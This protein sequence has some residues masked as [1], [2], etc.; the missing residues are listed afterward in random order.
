MKYIFVHIG[1]TGG[2]S[3][4]EIVNANTN[5]FR[6]YRT[7]VS[8][9]SNIVGLNCNNKDF[10]DGQITQIKNACNKHNG[11]TAHMQ[12]GL[13]NYMGDV[14]HTYLSIIRHPVKRLI[15]NYNYGL[16]QGMKNAVNSKDFLEYAEKY[17]HGRM[18][19][20]VNVS[21]I[22]YSDDN[23]VD[24]LIETALEHLSQDNYLFGFTSR[25]NEYLDIV[26][27][28]LGWKVNTNHTNK[29]GTKT[30]I[31]QSQIDAVTELAA[32]D[33]EFHNRALELYKTKY[34]K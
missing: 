9:V 6:G 4:R 3:F 32:K 14:D 8:E 19:N 7:P 21:G 10:N 29:T 15:S 2:A 20:L 16:Q 11:F 17:P 1:K 34:N 26:K 13:H 30:N 24:E 33:V 28:N 27:E 12:Y 5:L 22:P 31:T 25:Y 23:D 18:I